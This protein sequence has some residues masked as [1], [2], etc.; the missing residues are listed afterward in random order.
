MSAT[1]SEYI[2]Q[3]QYCRLTYI[4]NIISSYG[5]WKNVTLVMSDMNQANFESQFEFDINF[6][7]MLIATC[8]YKSRLHSSILIFLTH[9]YSKF[10]K[11]LW[12]AKKQYIADIW[13]EP[14]KS[15][16]PFWV[17]CQ[18]CT[19]PIL[20]NQRCREFEWIRVFSSISILLTHL[21]LKFHECLWVAKKHFI[22][23]LWYEADKA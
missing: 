2:V 11:F 23:D 16:V 17:R 9:L 22:A 8:S 21:Y 18:R 14:D 3:F 10:H 12:E 7:R 5:K 19:Q 20:I 1:A 6:V 13:Y 4:K 15:W